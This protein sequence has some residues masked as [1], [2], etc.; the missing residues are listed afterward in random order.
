MTTEDKLTDIA[1]EVWY[2]LSTCEDGATPEESVE[3][4]KEA[5]AIVLKDL[6]TL[7]DELHIAQWAKETEQMF[8]Q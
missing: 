5:L 2:I 4:I 8:N 7:R 3:Y 1:D 6:N